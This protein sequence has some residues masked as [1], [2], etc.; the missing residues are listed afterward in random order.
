MF[1]LVLLFSDR[2]A[3]RVIPENWEEQC[4]LAMDSQESS[5]SGVDTSTYVL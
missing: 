5:S 2:L 3:A 1:P 4:G